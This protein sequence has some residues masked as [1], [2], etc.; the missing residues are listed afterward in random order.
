M[1]YVIQ[2]FYKPSNLY[3]NNVRVSKLL[4]LTN[5][6]LLLLFFKTANLIN[7]KITYNFYDNFFLFFV[8]KY[9]Y[10]TNFFNFFC[11]LK[12]VNDGFYINNLSKSLVYWQFKTIIFFFK[13]YRNIGIE[14][15]FSNFL[16]F[17]IYYLVNK[18]AI[19]T[20]KKK[21][22]K[23]FF[24]YTFFL[25]TFLWPSFSNNFHF[26]LN[27]LLMIDSYLLF[28]FLNGPFFKIYSF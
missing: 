22:Y 15:V 28:K 6:N 21:S 2:N 19:L 12:N 13:F 17:N 23:N 11:T 25:I 9:F 18:V 26:Y 3:F 24:I 14:I 5:I 16:S 8:V 27:F 10:N 1:S 7:F 4:F 20:L